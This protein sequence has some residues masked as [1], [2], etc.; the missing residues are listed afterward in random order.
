MRRHHAPVPPSLAALD[1]T[2]RTAVESN[3]TF[4][5]YSTGRNN[6]HHFLTRYSLPLGHIPG[7]AEDAR[8]ILIQFLSH[9]FARGLGPSALNSGLWA[10]RNL[11]VNSPPL[12]RDP[13][14]GDKRVSTVLKSF[15]DKCAVLPTH[16]Q[17]LPPSA[18]RHIFSLGA[19]PVIPFILV[20][21]FAF[22]LR[23]S[24]Y[25]TTSSTG[26]RLQAQHVRLSPNSLRITITHSKGAKEAT[27]HERAFSPGSPRCLHTLFSAYLA[28]HPKRLPTDP[29]F[30]WLDGSPVTD[31]QL[32]DL[33]QLLATVAGLDGSKIS[34]HSLRGGGA[35][36]AFT[37]G[38]ND[39]FILREGR[40]ASTK[41]LL[42]YIRTLA[43]PYTYNVMQELFP[44]IFDTPR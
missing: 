4:S 12:F 23:V 26:C 40:W 7:S 32:N 14:A 44:G 17:A 27:H 6:W 8:D 13:S 5:N 10:V 15:K 33:I 1:S 31:T 20:F 11:W 36:A 43:E 39:L 38:K 25:T 16:K 37:M 29:A 2:A 28:V 30:Q 9:E 41:S 18:L 19:D 24:E 21:A 42:L 34:S 35:V 3:P 22:F